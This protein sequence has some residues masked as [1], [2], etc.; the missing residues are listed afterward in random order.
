MKDISLQEVQFGDPFSKPHS[1][2]WIDNTAGMLSVFQAHH[3]PYPLPIKDYIF[4]I[5]NESFIQRKGENHYNH[6]WVIF[7][8]H[9]L[10]RYLASA[11]HAKKKKDSKDILSCLSF[12]FSLATTSTGILLCRLSFSCIK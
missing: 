11:N 2:T 10:K 6:A 1:G 7:P 3:T 5:L 4:H 12:P 8:L 9:Y